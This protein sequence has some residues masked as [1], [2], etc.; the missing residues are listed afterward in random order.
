MAGSIEI[1]RRQIMLG[2]KNHTPNMSQSWPT[3]S[4]RFFARS[5]AKASA[6]WSGAGKASI[7]AG[8]PFVVKLRSAKLLEEAML[9]Y[10]DSDEV[11][12]III[13]ESL[14]ADCSVFEVSQYGANE[15]R[16][17]RLTGVYL[18]ADV[19]HLWSLG[20]LFIRKQDMGAAVEHLN[21]GSTD[22]QCD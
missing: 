3:W 21:S 6:T 10:R 5:R 7:F 12:I 18:T 9:T 22:Y 17:A 13:S 15:D 1:N 20:P 14:P 19:D 4:K 16:S 8:K 11:Y 2:E